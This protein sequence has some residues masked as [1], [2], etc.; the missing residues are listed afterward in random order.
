MK[1]ITI[2]ILL[3]AA[4]LALSA[5]TLLQNAIPIRQG[6]NIEWFRSSAS[7]D[8]G[9][10]YVWS[11]TRNGGRDLFAQL[12]TPTGAKAWGPDG[13]TVDDAL[14]RQE[15]PMIVATSD[16]NVIIAYVD[17][18]VDT[19]WGDIRANKITPQ[20]VKLWG[21]HGVSICNEPDEQIS[22][23]MV[24]D[25]DGGAYIA[26]QDTRATQTQTFLQHVNANGITT[27][28]TN[29]INI[30]PVDIQNMGSN[31]FWE[32]TSGGGVMAYEY[33]NDIFLIR[34]HK[35]NPNAIVW[36]PIQIAPDLNPNASNS[37]PKMAPDGNNGFIFAWEHLDTQVHLNPRIKLQRI[38]INGDRLWGD[39][40]VNLTTAHIRN[41][42]RHRIIEVADGGAVIAWEDQRNTALRPEVFI[43]KISL[44]GTQVWQE[45]GIPVSITADPSWQKKSQNDEN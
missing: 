35:D 11:D 12:I 22:I 42:E 21:N 24:P 5:Q 26:W 27:F 18:S 8:E 33:I 2:I 23:N 16:G 30:N 31:T 6:T 43:Q 15:D 38:D 25:Q 13:L 45:D 41:Q 36:G 9:V 17:F 1:K 4:C 3:I 39:S 14:D 40:G 28:Q 32:D 10:V 37:N 44:L 29:G 34:F 20:G 7:I 19:V